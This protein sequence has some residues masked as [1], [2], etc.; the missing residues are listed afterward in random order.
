MNSHIPA[1]ML[2]LQKCLRGEEIHN[3]SDHELL[4]VII[5]SGTRNYPVMQL[6]Q[7]LMEEMG[8]VSGLL[9]SGIRELASKPGMGMV[10]AIR[11]HSA[12]EL[13]KRAMVKPAVI[14]H[15]D[16]PA[17][18][19]HLLVH[20]MMGLDREKFMSLV[21][22]N[23]NRLIKKSFISLGTVSEAIVH[24]REVFREAIKEGGSS[25]IV[26]H[27]HP[28]GILKPSREDITTTKRLM[29]SGAL[30]G[31]PLLDHVIISN[32]SFLSMKEE[33]YLT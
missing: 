2:P 22:N 31:I 13:G 9:R 12:I 3:L 33:G 27:N 16:S 32:S 7:L 17:S 1:S 23:K 21:L 20:D 6:S 15:I 4:A 10:K 28:S 8:S 5:G 29:E 24:P 14:D 25:V 19:W 11:V 18:V 26:A 30:L